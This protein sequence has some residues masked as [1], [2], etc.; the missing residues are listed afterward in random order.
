[1][2]TPGD[3]DQIA[4]AK[5]ILKVLGL[6]IPIGSS[7]LDSSRFSSGSIHY[8]LLKKYKMPLQSKPDGLGVDILEQT[9]K[10]YPDCNFFAIGP[11]SNIGKYLEKHSN[12]FIEFATMQG[13]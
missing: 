8:D 9:L 12:T 5:L 4:I 10:N 6:N 13:G 1:M 2:I 7:C 3:P 11:V